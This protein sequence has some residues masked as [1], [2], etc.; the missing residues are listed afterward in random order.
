MTDTAATNANPET[1]SFDYSRY[2]TERP[3]GV[4]ALSL[5]VGNI[6]CAACVRTIETALEG[7]PGVVEAR[8][9]LTNRRLALAWR[10]GAADPARLLSRVT[11]RGYRLAPFDAALMNKQDRTRERELLRAMAVAGFAAANVMLLSVSVWAGLAADMG[12]ATRGLMHWVSAL[13]ALP[14]VVY[15]GRPF[16]HSAVAALRGG[17]VNMDVPIS[18]AVILAAGMS[19]AQTASGGDR[20]YFDA[21]VMLLFLLLVGRDL[22][23]RMRGRARDVAANLLGLNAVAATVVDRDGQRRALP[24]ADVRAGMIVHVAPGDRVPVDGRVT[25]GRSEV[26][27]SLVSG[28]TLPQPVAPGARVFAGT[29]NGGGAL[30]ITVTAAGDD[31]L[32]ADIVR[33]MESAGQGRSA[34]VRLADRAAQIYVPLVHAAAALTAV[35]WLA[36][37]APWTVAVTTA[38]AVLIITCPCALGLAV[39]AVQVAAASR[40]LRS[41]I[42][43]KSGDA[44][45]R[46]AQVD[47]VVLDKTG[48]LTRGQPDLVG[49]V[50]GCGGSVADDLLARAASL[51]SAS[52]HPLARALVRAAEGAGLHLTAPGDVREEAGSGLEGMVSGHRLRLGRRDWCGSADSDGASHSEPGPDRSEG[53]LRNAGGEAGTGGDGEPAAPAGPELWIRDGDAPPR[54]LCFV[55]QPR[56]DAASVVRGLQGQGLGVSLLSG[57]RPVVVQAVAR[58]TGIDDWAGALPPAGKISRIQALAASGRRVLMVGD[59]LNDAPALA[60]AWVSMSPA[61]AADISQTAAD[62]VFQGERLAPVHEALAVA[63]KARRLVLQNFG[64]AVAYNLVAVP[65]AALG[66]ASPLVAAVAMSASSLLVTLNALRL[67]RRPRVVGA[68]PSGDA[69]ADVMAA[70]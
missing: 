5:L 19:L 27:N 51:A 30:T 54:R 48:T 68:A 55:D 62:L 34:L 20:V 10:D 26:D 18:L 17:H 9:N 15:A 40:L 13:I 57:D 35:A 2:V 36:A 46:L 39:P 65:V 63:R 32:L 4:A 1:G 41:G 28:E 64:L 42:L 37:G 6:H 24:V 60:A 7:Q 53:G 8:V 58:H 70:T 3:G 12:P 23:Q 45:E 22:D 52:R 16:F 67:H 47:H 11:A 43:V 44:L 21:S 29:L 56:S 33:L 50:E 49:K 66:L 59:G 25:A 69:A 14:A 38:I 61:S 31:T